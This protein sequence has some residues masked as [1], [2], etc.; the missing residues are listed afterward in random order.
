MSDVLHGIDVFVAAVEDGSFAA[1]ATRLHLT[2]SAVAKTVARIETRL[3]VRLFHRTTRS[4]ALTEDGQLYYERCVRALDELRAGAAALDSGRREVAGRLRVSAPV[5]FGRRCVA[6]VLAQLTRRHPALELEISFNDRLVDLVEDGF[7]LAIRNGEIGN[8]TGLMTRVV[9]LQRMSVCAAPSYLEQ[10]GRPE[11]LA[12]LAAHQAIHYG[13]AG[14]AKGWA[15]PLPGGMVEAMPPGRLRFDDLET[16]ADAAE[17][18]HGLAW[19]PCWL[20]RDRVR[21]G[22]LVPLLADLPRLVFKTHALWPQSPYLPLRVRLAID[23][24]AEKLPGSAEL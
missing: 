21:T 14:H 19:L 23:A 13:R 6:P 24:L 22:A 18:G 20:I 5:L 7:D 15:F 4:Q 17:A 12:D 1:A 11:N 3:G 8:G 2:R 9:G 10:H 16:I